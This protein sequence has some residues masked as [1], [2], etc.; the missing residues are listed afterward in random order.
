M[1][2]HVYEAENLSQGPIVREQRREIRE[3]ERDI[4]VCTY[5]SARGSLLG[6]HAVLGT[7]NKRDVRLGFARETD[8][9]SER[10]E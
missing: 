2:T 4:H 3:E 8:L 5:V 6:A 7:F 1:W 10:G 9:S